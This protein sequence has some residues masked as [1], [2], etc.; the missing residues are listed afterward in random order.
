M[1]AR[2]NNLKGQGFHTN[3]ERINRK[4]RPKTSVKEWMKTVK[5]NGIEAV[6][7]TDIFN[8]FQIVL[9]MSEEQIKNM[10]GDKNVIMILR[11]VG[12]EMLSRKGIDTIERLLDRTHGKAK[13]AIE[14]TGEMIIEWKEEK[15]YETKPK[16]N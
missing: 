1:A 15:T 6:T 13:Q 14:T 7:K 9:G 8:A 11:I 5:A 10:V 16:A 4:G 12:K 2:N 3:P